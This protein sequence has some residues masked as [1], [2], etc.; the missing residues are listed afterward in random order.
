MGNPT[1]RRTASMRT[2]PISRRH[3][4]AIGVERA[5]RVIG[6]FAIALGVE[7]GGRAGEQQPVN[8]R[9]NFLGVHQLRHRRHKQPG[10]I[11]VG[12]RGIEVARHHSLR[13]LI[14]DVAI[15]GDHAKHRAVF[16]SPHD[17]STA[18]A[19]ACQPSQTGSS[20]VKSS[21]S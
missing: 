13:G 15:A 11:G 1:D 12:K 20:Q 14:I 3:F 8:P 4:V 19:Q 21:W 16:V 2:A 17:S 5:R 18:G 10:S 7:I 6:Q 9:R